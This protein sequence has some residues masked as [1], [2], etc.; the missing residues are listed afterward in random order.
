MTW[1]FLDNFLCI[2]ITKTMKNSW[3]GNITK[4]RKGNS[5][6]EFTTTYRAFFQWCHHILKNQE[7]KKN[8]DQIGAFIS[9]NRKNFGKTMRHDTQSKSNSL[10]LLAKEKKK[11]VF[12]FKQKKLCNPWSVSRNLLLL[13]FKYVAV[14]YRCYATIVP[15]YRSQREQVCI[16]KFVKIACM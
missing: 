2:Q 1:Q 8:R 16:K 7:F 4:N 15:L 12:F 13:L 10:L 11:E 9:K 14:R 3:T 5:R 6:A